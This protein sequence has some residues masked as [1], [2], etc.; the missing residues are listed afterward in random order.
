MLLQPF[1]SIY[2]N[3]LGAFLL[4]SLFVICVS[5]A[6]CYG[7]SIACSYFGGCPREQPPLIQ[8]KVVFIIKLG[9]LLA[10]LGFVFLAYDKVIV[11]Q[12]DYSAG[13]AAAREQWRTLGD[14]RD[15][16]AS[17]VFSVFGY[18][19]GSAYMLPLSFA[20]SRRVSFSDSTRM[21]VILVSFL[22]LLA[23]SFLTGGRS[24]ILL[25]IAFCGY[26]FQGS[27]GS[28][29]KPLFTRRIFPLS[30]YA[31]F[32]FLVFYVLYVFHSRSAASGEDLTIYSVAF[33]DYL[34][35][36]PVDSSFAELSRSP[37]SSP[38]LLLGL[39]ASYI[40]HSFATTSAIADYSGS[41]TGT[42]FAYPLSLLYKLGV[43]SQPTAEWF[44]SGR[45][46][47]LP[48]AVY[49]QGGLLALFLFSLIL[50]LIAGILVSLS[51]LQPGNLYL[52]LLCSLLEAVLLLSPLLFATELLSFP[53]VA[54]SSLLLIAMSCI[55]VKKK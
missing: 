7:S 27:L 23:N 16:Q 8:A 11:Q 43:A 49:L 19:L 51:F 15:G 30:L 2:P 53:F 26:G 44:L 20:F 1:R 34:G 47:S 5:A 3:V 22:L 52:F 10:A 55:V 17:S 38:A 41:E 37:F 28:R 32:S 13:V 24:S 42:L 35:L 36:E 6:Y 25:A 48:G 14:A 4:Q 40:S 12:V 31:L 45:F 18:L 33:L 54:F 9:L 29:R 50:G 21:I 39:A 46:P